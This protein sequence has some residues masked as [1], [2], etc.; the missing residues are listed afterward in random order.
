MKDLII[1]GD[2]FCASSSGWPSQL[3]GILN[4]NLVSQGF[5]GHHWWK[6]KCYLDSLDTNNAQAIIVVHTNATRIPTEDSA[7][8]TFDHSQEP[9]NELE[10]S[11]KLYNKY[12][13]NQNFLEWAQQ[14]WF[15]ELESQY[16]NV[17]HLHSFPWSVHYGKDAHKNIEQNLCALSL[18]ELG[19]K[20][21][22]LFNDVRTNH[23][24]D[25]NNT[26]LATQLADIV[27]NKQRQ[28]DVTKFD[29]KVKNW[30]DWN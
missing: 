5:P 11:V 8:V 18:N 23:L 6:A 29:L 24:N 28:L 14:Q 13:L 7:L 3:A 17:I 21:F 4:L 16:K 27:N 1:T 25:F 9:T 22:T 26:V 12:I 30:F 19:A 10:L 20:E 2:S 15:L